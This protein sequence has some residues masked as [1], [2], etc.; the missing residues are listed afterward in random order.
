[1]PKDK[2]LII[3]CVGVWDTVG[4]YGVPA[5]LG[6]GALA[7][8]LTSWTRGFHD[9]E[10][11]KN[12]EYRPACHGHRRGAPRLPG[13]RLG[14]DR[15]RSDRPGVEQVW[16][17]GAHSNVGGGYKES[18]LSDMALLWMISRVAELT[19]L[20]FD[21]DYVK[22]ALLAVLGLLSLPLQSRLADQQH[23]AVPPPDPR[24]PQGAAEGGRTADQRQ[25]ALEREAAARKVR[26]SRS[27]EV[28]A[29][30]AQ[31]P[32]GGRRL[33]RA[34]PAREATTSPCAATT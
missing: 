22:R 11:G 15:A 10:I 29:L 20:E 4:S 13:H 31:E 24:A 1:M 18:G 3:K 27:D 34:Q 14:H 2:K 19:G 21:D 9:N 33:Y 5:G 16:F 12:I 28:S 7:R 6:L 30:H 32:A 17:A 8:K 25:G 23:L 26:P